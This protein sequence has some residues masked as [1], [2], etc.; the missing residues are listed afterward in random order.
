MNTCAHG[1][2]I[3]ER[4]MPRSARTFTF[5][6]PMERMT[7]RFAWHY[8]EFPHDVN[9]LFG[10]RGAVRVK[11]V[12]NGVAVDRSLMPT[13]SGYH[14]LVLGSEL[15]KKAGIQKV[16]D[17]VQVELRLDPEPNRIDIPE[18]LAETLDFFPEMKAAW[19]QLKP[20]MQR[21]MCYWVSSGRTVVTRA[22]RVAGLLR[23]FETGE[24]QV[25]K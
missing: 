3:P 16:G 2:L 8:V 20:G 13:K 7:S 18:E 23:R 24:F 21:S 25:G 12:I 19:D 1:Q 4:A 14:I 22:K 6:A 17:P 11:C 10:K 9:E 5:T 15:R